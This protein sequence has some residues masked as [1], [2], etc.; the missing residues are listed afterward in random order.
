[1]LSRFTLV[2]V[3]TRREMINSP[4]NILHL[5]LIAAQDFLLQAQTIHGTTG[6]GK[7]PSLFVPTTSARLRN[8]RHLFAAFHV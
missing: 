8:P 3:P 5:T 1:M 4:P 2:I 7:E 6:E